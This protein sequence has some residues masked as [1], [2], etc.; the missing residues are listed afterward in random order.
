MTDR[1]YFHMEN[2]LDLKKKFHS[3]LK[4]IKTV[5]ELESLEKEYLG[6]KGVLKA[7]LLQ[8]KSLPIEERQSQGSQINSTK[9]EFETILSQKKSELET[10]EIEKK[11]GAPQDWTLPGNPIAR[12]RTHPLTLILDEVIDLFGD[13]GFQVARGPEIETDEN[14]FGSLNIPKD[15][16]AREMHDTF[17]IREDSE[18]RLLR[19]H[20]SPVQIRLM[21]ETTPPIRII[22]PGKVFRHEAIDATHSS[23]FHQVEGLVVGNN[24]SFAD[25]K[26]TLEMANMKLFGSSVRT[27]FRPSYFPFVE[28]G[29]EVD[30][31]CT[32]CKGPGSNCPVCKG[33]GWIEMLGAGMVHPN[34]FK[35]VGYDPKIWTGFAFGLGIERIAMIRYGIEDMRLFYENHL[36]FLSQF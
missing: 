25:L 27:R 33:S 1:H 4:Q 5:L 18:K 11:L 9:E 10:I 21:K 24:V 8:L 2:L 19:T 7:Q 14:N 34:V 17:Y 22:A 28:P 31:S 6:A 23:V 16:P 32:L 13:L 3:A 30:I 12:G 36:D 29:A 26:G 20:T 35:A 15:H